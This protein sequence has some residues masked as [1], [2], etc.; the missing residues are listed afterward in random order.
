M[1]R[2]ERAG[3]T[4]PDE[5]ADERFEDQRDDDRDDGRDENDARPIE[6][7][8]D[9]TGGNRRQSVAVDLLL[10][11][12]SAIFRLAFLSPFAARVNETNMCAGGV[13]GSRVGFESLVGNAG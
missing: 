7:G 9:D 13:P 12:S 8:D 2:A 4:Q 11:R 6:D 3:E 5:D 1:K 10:N